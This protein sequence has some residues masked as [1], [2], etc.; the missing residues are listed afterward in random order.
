VGTALGDGGIGVVVDRE[1]HEAA[2]GKA[3]RVSDSGRVR[4]V[5]EEVGD[6][7][8]EQEEVVAVEAGGEVGE[9]GGLEKRDERVLTLI[10]S[11]L[12]LF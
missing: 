10:C 2:G 6:G 4:E 12:V 9:V 7:G 3:E 11:V 5:G 8:R 1:Q